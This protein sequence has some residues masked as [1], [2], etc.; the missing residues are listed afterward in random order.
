[1]VRGARVAQ[2]GP[3]LQ[4]GPAVPEDLRRKQKKKVGEIS[5]KK[6]PQSSTFHA[7]FPRV[8]NYKALLSYSTES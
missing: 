2:G 1:M 6:N 5:T 8:V 7:I 3:S 4:G